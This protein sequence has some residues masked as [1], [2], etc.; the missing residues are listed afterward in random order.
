MRANPRQAKITPLWAR[1]PASFA[2]GFQAAPLGVA[3]TMTCLMLV[4]HSLPFKLVLAIISFFIL[5]KYSFSILEYSAEGR[6]K[7]PPASYEVLATGLEVPLKA[8]GILIFFIFCIYQFTKFG[9]QAIFYGSTLLAIAIIPASF[10]ILATTQSFIAAINPAKIFNII[11]QAKGS[12]LILMGLLYMLA[13]AQDNVAGL[14]TET[15]SGLIV[16]FLV[17]FAGFYFTFIAFHMMGYLLYQFHQEI[18]ASDNDM[19]VQVEA[20]DDE[21]QRSMVVSEL[22]EKLMAQGETKA[23]LTEFRSVITDIPD[24]LSLR[25]RYHNQA[26]AEGFYQEM[27]THGSGYISLLLEQGNATS[28]TDV[29]LDCIAHADLKGYLK[30]TEYLPIIE[31]LRSKGKYQDAIKLVGLFGTQHPQSDLAPHVYLTAAKLLCEDLN[32]VDRAKNMLNVALK[33]FPNH[34]LVPQLQRYQGILN[35]L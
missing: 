1:M 2:Y 19:Q 4:M 18:G 27:L 30:E 8:L 15:S 3:V 7:A 16:S 26:L 28:A 35:S 24:D 11:I 5:Y 33:I 12:Y 21:A 29:Y 23:A 20:V 9:S 25:R 14:I 17:G 32:K 10:M 34:E 22:Y 31:T 6:K 13:M